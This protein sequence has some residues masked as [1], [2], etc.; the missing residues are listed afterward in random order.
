MIWNADCQIVEFGNAGCQS[1]KGPFELHDCCC[2]INF[3]HR[4]DAAVPSP[5]KLSKEANPSPHQIEEILIQENGLFG[6]IN[7]FSH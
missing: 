1:T 3:G 4:E 7:T 2:W 6:E 5:D